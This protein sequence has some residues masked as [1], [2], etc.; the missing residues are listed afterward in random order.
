VATSSNLIYRQPKVDIFENQEGFL[1]LADMPGVEKSQLSIEIEDW[2][3]GLEGRRTVFVDQEKESEE[4]ALCYQRKFQLSRDID[5]EKVEAQL[6]DGV[7]HINLPKL[8]ESQ[9]RQ[10]LLKET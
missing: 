10:I 6:K 3:L 7:L 4:A 2:V 9:P 5:Q 1:L 8:P